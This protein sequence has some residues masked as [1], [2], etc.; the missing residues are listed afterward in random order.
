MRAYIRARVVYML[1]SRASTHAQSDTREEKAP[2]RITLIRCAA[3]RSAVS[4]IPGNARRT[5]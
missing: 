5:L 1:L 3:V 4:V 2:V